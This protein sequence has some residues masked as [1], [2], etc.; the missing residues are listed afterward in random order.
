MIFIHS[1]QWWMIGLFVQK[2]LQLDDDEFL[3]LILINPEY[4]TRSRKILIYTFWLSPFRR[5]SLCISSQEKNF[6]ENRRTINI[7]LMI[8][9]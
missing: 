7:S 3:L 8:V 2:H 4:L 9:K 5:Q 6:D 1:D